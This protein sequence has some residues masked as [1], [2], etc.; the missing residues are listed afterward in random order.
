MSMVRVTKYGYLYYDFHYRGVRCREYTGN[1]NNAK[2]LKAMNATLRKIEGEIS[3]GTFDYRTY[4]PDSKIAY[5][6]Y[7]G[8]NGQPGGHDPLFDT[9]AETWYRNNIIS[10]KPSFQRDVRSMLNRHLIPHFKGQPVSKI[11]KWMLKEF[12]TELAQLDGRRGMLMSNKRINNIMVV[13]RLILSEAAEEYGFSNPFMNFKPL[14]VRRSDVMPLSLEEVFTFLEHV[15]EHY[16]DYYVIRF[17]TGMRTAEIDGLKWNYVDF[18]GKKIRIRETWQNRL[19]VSPKT[20]TSVRDIDMAKN[21]EEALLRQKAKTGDGE[22]VFRTRNGKPIDRDDVTKR[23][24]YPTLAKAGLAR[25]TPYQSR[26]TTASIW[27][28][29]VENPEGVARHL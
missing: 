23:I 16:H 3:L 19:W 1:Q 13:C 27:L 10:W 26:H 21:V 11:T 7:L 15:P 24:W 12:R 25:R 14:K 18:A 4:F 9:Y 20:E 22:L 2:N 17:F 5:K 28:A 8:A 29:S 6:F